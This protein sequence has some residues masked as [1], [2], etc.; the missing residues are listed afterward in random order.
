MKIHWNSNITPK[1][2]YTEEFS[3][4]FISI[5][6]ALN[7]ILM[8]DNSLVHANTFGQGTCSF[9]LQRS[10]RE[11]KRQMI[12]DPLHGFWFFMEK[13][14]I[15]SQG[16][17]KGQRMIHPKSSQ[18]R[19]PECGK[20]VWSNRQPPRTQ[21]TKVTIKEWPIEFAM[22]P[23]MMNG[24]GKYGSRGKHNKKL[25]RLIPVRTYPECNQVVIWRHFSR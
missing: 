3:F 9:F 25:S 7:V 16:G 4:G 20:R 8:K 11:G 6:A 15:R 2:D 22:S 23:E 24:G 19:L 12:G 1:S 18:L 5:I 10:K 14:L 13:E 21:W 17:C